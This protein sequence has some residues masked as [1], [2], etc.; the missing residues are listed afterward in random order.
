MKAW[1]MT[2]VEAEGLAGARDCSHPKH[3]L[4]LDGVLELAMWRC[5][6]IR[7]LPVSFSRTPVSGASISFSTVQALICLG[8]LNAWP[9]KLFR[10]QLPTLSV[11][12][13]LLPCS[14]HPGDKLQHQHVLQHEAVRDWASQSCGGLWC[15]P[16]MACGGK[17]ALWP[18]WRESYTL[19]I[20]SSF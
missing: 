20:S 7:L 10:L 17:V 16:V 18:F 1:A 2:M 9:P 3:V 14:G 12:F 13:D 15:V 11:A 19:A 4:R 5:L 6:D 8:M